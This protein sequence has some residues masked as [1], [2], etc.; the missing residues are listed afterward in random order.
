MIDALLDREDCNAI[1]VDWT[2]GANG[3]YGQAAGNTRL[4]GAQIAELIRFLVSNNVGSSISSD[5]FY[6]VGNS[7]GAHI[8]GHAGKFLRDRGMLLGRITGKFTSER[9]DTLAR[10]SKD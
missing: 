4:V 3:L 10:Q 6:I 9:E 7:L 5:R 8:A 1:L 2:G